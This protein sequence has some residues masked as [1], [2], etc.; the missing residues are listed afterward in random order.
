[1]A[2]VNVN[3]E[4]ADVYYRYK[5]PALQAKVEG[6]GNGMKTVIVNMV[7]IA[8]ALHRPPS[9]STK[10]FG[11]ELGAQVQ[12]DTKKERYIVNGPHDAGKLQDMLD[13]FIKRF[14]LCKECGNPETNL[15]VSRKQTINQICIACGY[16]T[17]VDMRHKLTTFI[18][19]NPPNPPSSGKTKVSKK[20]SSKTPP[21]EGTDTSAMAS[22][23]VP[24]PSGSGSS[25][26]GNVDDDDWSV[27]TSADAVKQRM[28]SSLTTAAATL[29]I[30]D[31]LELPED[32]RLDLLE[33]FIAKEMKGGQLAPD[34]ESVFKESRR[35]EL[36]EK[37]VLLVCE[38]VLNANALDQLK[39]YSKLFLQFLRE[40][41]KAQK[42][43]LGALEN[44]VGKRH[45]ALL[46]RVP[47]IWKMSYDLDLVDEEVF[48]EWEGKV[49]KR[50]VSKEMSQTIRDR[51]TPFLKWLREA[52]EEE[53]SDDE[54]DI[55]VVY[56]HK[57]QAQV[58][59]EERQKI[60]TAAAAA[61]NDDGGDDDDLD[62]D[63]I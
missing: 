33:A 10:Y 19:R 32:K 30:T 20:N 50:Y 48:L 54:D 15:E 51:A 49:S 29:A 56:T 53:E 63:N 38:A 28:A 5:M 16:R 26:D 43:F 59:K 57:S 40:N 27:D 12:M 8:K 14:V 22:D 9:Y 4:I 45:P 37:T 36:V 25:V 24:R 34:N 58:E 13:G 23:A 55:E 31:D 11:C 17:G 21:A 60:K 62:I 52:E 44:L 61:G 2:T 42:H 39:T 35:L 41:K 3:R 46:N 1:M 6:K 47:H 7:A 18:L